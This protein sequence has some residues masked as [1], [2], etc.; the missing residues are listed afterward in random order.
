VKIKLLT[1]IL[2]I[3]GTVCWARVFDI[4]TEKFASFFRGSYAPSALGKTA[5]E[6]ASAN[7]EIYNAE[8]KSLQSGEFGF[9][10]ATRYL[11]IKYSIEVVRTPSLSAVIATN[12]SGTELYSLASDISAVVPKIGFEFN[13]K[14]WRQTRISLNTSVGQGNL[15]LTNAY[16]FTEAGT[17]ATSRTDYTEEGRA[18]ATLLD[19]ALAFETL[20][21]DTTTFLIDVGYRQMKF[22]EIKHNRDC[23]GLIGN[24]VKGDVMV[25]VDGTNRVIDLTGSYVGLGFRFW[26]F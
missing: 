6:N 16:T 4:N 22:T 13:L 14:Q 3:P 2:L 19:G 17:A 24:N 15:V 8:V 26:I 18:T 20:L 12:A 21:F 10:H 23:A 5:F 11:N 25:D 7:N 9:I 1:F